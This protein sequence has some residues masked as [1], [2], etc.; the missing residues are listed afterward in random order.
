MLNSIIPHSKIKKIK[1]I[2]RCIGPSMALAIYQIAITKN[3]PV[4]VLAEDT[5]H[6]EQLKNEISF[7]NLNNIPIDFFPEWETLPYDR[8]S[9]HQDIISN[10]LRVLSE[11]KVSNHKIIIL[12][13][14][15]LFNRLPPQS[16]INS[17]TLTLN[18]GDHIN[19]QNMIEELIENGYRK[20]SQV[21]EHGEYATRGS[22]LDIYPMGTNKPI[23]I[24]IYDDAIE[25]LRYFNA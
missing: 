5:Q 18:I 23:R 15:S 4:L 10:R 25:S 24:E 21:E 8:F 13:V 11:Q 3:N 12:P 2:G 16:Y 17:H 19:Y 7:F 22:L 1:S 9:P 6:G 14:C 20:V